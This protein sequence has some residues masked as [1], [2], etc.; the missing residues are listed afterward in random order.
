MTAERAA[1]AERQ[2]LADLLRSTGIIRSGP[3]RVVVDREG[4]SAAWGLY[5]PNVS[6]THR[7]MLLAGRALLGHLATF[8]STQLASFGHT[9]MPLLSSCILLGAGRYT[10]L[11]IREKRKAYLTRQLIDGPADTGR[12]VVVVDDSISSGT[13]LHRSIQ[14]LEAEGFDVEGAVALVMFPYREGAEWAYRCGYRVEAV[15][16]IWHDLG[17][18]QPVERRLPRPIEPTPQGPAVESGL[19][20]AVAARRIAQ[21]YLST[22]TAPQP[23][24]RFD[25]DYDGRG[26]VFVSF[27]DRATE[28]R[29]ARDGFWHFDSDEAQPCRDVVAA[30]VRAVQTSGGAV[31][32]ERLAALKVAVTFLGP[33]SGSRPRS[34]TSTG[35][36]LWSAARS[37]DAS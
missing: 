11:S 24:D 6:L 23:P 36:R 20:P 26:G 5:T 19:A 34:W 22:G 3:D 35:T 12:S 29:A 14:V 10:G 28:R 8:R 31:S 30:T 37:Q 16:N 25:R 15:F 4:R 7:G 18:G 2:E 9:A 32:T 33:W 13:S 1:A 21:S 17:M 27:R